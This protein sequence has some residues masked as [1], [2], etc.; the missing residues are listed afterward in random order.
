MRLPYLRELETRVD[1]W[2]DR[3]AGR[4]TIALRIRRGAA[5]A[6]LI[7][8]GE[9][10]AVDRPTDVG[11]VTHCRQQ[12]LFQIDMVLEDVPGIGRRDRMFG[13]TAAARPEI[14]R[15]QQHLPTELEAVGSDRRD[16]VGDIV[17]EIGRHSGDI[18]L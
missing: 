8:D 3:A 4:G 16:P 5:L 13:I 10:E 12:I 17:P 18:H 1:R 9:G 6:I 2:L 14:A 7:K 11:A 15:A